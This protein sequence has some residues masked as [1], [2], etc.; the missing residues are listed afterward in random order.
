MVRLR[1]SH[2]RN[3]RLHRCRPLLRSGERHNL[4][5]H[6]RYIGGVPLGNRP[7][8]VRR[9]SRSDRSYYCRCRRTL[10]HLGQPGTAISNIPFT[11][12]CIPGCPPDGRAWRFS[13]VRRSQS[14]RDH[15]RL[16]AECSTSTGGIA[17]FDTPF[18]PFAA[19]SVADALG[20]RRFV[21]RSH[22]PALATSSG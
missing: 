15:C 3:H 9:V 19:F 5:T 4:A 18:D 21:H 2:R 20:L 10:L 22:C 6:H 13:S 8:R 17:P 7:G 14:R 16:R 11:H 1:R 12:N